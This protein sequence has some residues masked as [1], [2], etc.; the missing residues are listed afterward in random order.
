MIYISH[1][2][3][4]KKILLEDSICNNEAI[5]QL[6]EELCSDDYEFTYEITFIDFKSIP[7]SLLKSLHKVKD[8]LKITTT[9]R[10]LWAYLSKLGL[11]NKYLDCIGDDFSNRVHVPIKAIAIGGSAGSI[12]KIIPIIESLPYT[13][14]S[15]FIVVHVLADEKSYLSDI[16]QH[17][18]AYKVHKATHNMKVEKNSIYIAQPN[19]HLIV[20]D[21]FIYLESESK[22][23]YARPS[24]DITFKSLV[25]EYSESL[26]AI[27]L[28]GYGSDG[29]HSLKEL[30]ESNCEII[31]ENPKECEAKEM[32]LN[33]IETKNF[34]KIL[35]LDQIIEY[36]KLSLSTTVDMKDEIDSFLENIFLIYGYDYRDYE[37]S[38]IIRR[39][40]LTMGQ[41]FITD[42]KEFERAVMDDENLFARLVRAFS[43]N[44]T[45]F[46][47]NPEVF[48]KVKKEIVPVL[49]KLENIRIWCA[50]CSKGKEPYSIA[51]LLDEAGLLGKCQIYA[52][53]FNKTILE[54]AKN[55]L[56]AKSELVEFEKNY[57]DSG[58]KE[59]SKRWFNIEDDFIEIKK[60]IRNRVLFFKHNLVTDGSI[61]EFNLIFCRNVLIYFNEKLQKYVFYTIDNSLD[62][63][64]FLVLGESEKMPQEY[65]YA[66]LGNKIYMRRT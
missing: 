18:T 28:C 19:N 45:T 4:I 34:S 37:R 26:L 12:E 59:D 47:R 9:H 56:F 36:L 7:A 1:S 57:K 2:K 53:D 16:L 43:I 50:G 48:N 35:N 8:R 17:V 27:L 66:E 29:S 20:V 40:E 60:E 25:Y 55:G 65:Q 61:N 6:N 13:D 44:V 30:K 31:I 3:K 62:K 15:I 33:A 64:G 42:F 38:S 39:I 21:G 14:I 58:G 23:N 49:E 5:E 11:N 51:M 32:P 52:T 46:F 24:I 41:N 10:S 63:N 54:E 22:L